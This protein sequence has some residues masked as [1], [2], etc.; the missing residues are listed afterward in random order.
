MKK[1]IPF[2]P[3]PSNRTSSPG[4]H[5]YFKVALL[6][7][8]FYVLA[9]NK[10]PYVSSSQFSNVFSRG[11]QDIPWSHLYK[12]SIHNEVDSRRKKIT[13]V[14]KYCSSHHLVA[15]LDVYAQLSSCSPPLNQTCQGRRLPTLSPGVRRCFRPLNG[16]FSSPLCLLMGEVP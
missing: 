2:I 8:A 15:Y 6:I 1:L 9:P 7:C 12:I 5:Y 13:S 16:S 11:Q 10:G 4:F 3:S 14:D